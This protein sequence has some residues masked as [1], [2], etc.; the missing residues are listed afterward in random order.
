ML[1]GE[2]CECMARMFRQ[3]IPGHRPVWTC[4]QVVGLAGEGVGVE[5][6]VEAMVPA[7]K[8]EGEEWG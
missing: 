7:G 8:E 4:V 2:E 6:E 1:D 3:W 5:V